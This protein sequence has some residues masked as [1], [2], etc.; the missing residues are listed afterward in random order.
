MTLNK[1]LR[2]FTE[3]YKN[4][5]AGEP[6]QR[7]H[8]EGPRIVEIKANTTDQGIQDAAFRKCKVH[9]TRIEGINYHCPGCGS[10]FCL[11]CIANVLVPEERC[12]V[13]EAPVDID[14]EFRA[15]IRGALGNVT[16]PGIMSGQVTIIAP[17]IWRRFE[18]LELDEDII[19]EV[20]DRLKHIPPADRMKY[21]DVYFDDTEDRG[22][23]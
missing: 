21:L 17:E 7:E 16:D 10:V 3:R 8:D 20:I 4:S 14:D 18:E 13:C 2:E 12:M 5:Q 23:F 11:A 9:R 1:N 15:I 22:D 19:D 6:E